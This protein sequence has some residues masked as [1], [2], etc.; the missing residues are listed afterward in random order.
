MSDRTFPE[1]MIEANGER[2]LAS[3]IVCAE[4]GSVGFYPHKRGARRRPPTAVIQ[5]FHAMG[6]S[7]RGAKDRCVECARARRSKKG[8]GMG[9]ALEAAGRAAVVDIVAVSAARAPTFEERQIINLKLVEVYLNPEAGYRPGWTDARV[10][11]DLGYPKEWVTDI[12]AAIFGP[13][14]V[15]PEIEA[16]LAASEKAVA[17]FSKLEGDQVAIA[18]RVATMQGELQE[19]ITEIRAAFSTISAQMAETRRLEAK[20][21]KEIGQ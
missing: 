4:C 19:A 12:R 13:E 14:G 16:F 21:R 9:E 7:L 18:R 3:K 10:G 17:A 8:T 5:H 2:I 11:R 20:I 1:E 6:W 15:T